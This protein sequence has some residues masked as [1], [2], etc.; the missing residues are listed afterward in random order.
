MTRIIAKTYSVLDEGGHEYHGTA[1]EIVAE[2]H[3][4]SFSQAASDAAWMRD[5]S[6][7]A[8]TQ[9]G[10]DIDTSSAEAFIAGM[11]EAGLLKP[12]KS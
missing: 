4:L 10:H 5:V 2:M 8:F 12:A 3:N 6:D 1:K 7:R 9:T 11:L